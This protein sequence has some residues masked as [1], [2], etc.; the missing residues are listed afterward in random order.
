MQVGCGMD[1]IFKS[2]GTPKNAKQIE[3]KT[4]CEASMSFV[5]CDKNCMQPNFWFPFS[6]SSRFGSLR[7]HRFPFHATVRTTVCEKSRFFHQFG[8]QQLDNHVAGIVR[9]VPIVL[10]ADG[11]LWG[12][13]SAPASEAI[14]IA[15]R[16]RWC[17]VVRPMAAVVVAIVAAAS[18]FGFVFHFGNTQATADSPARSRTPGG[19]ARRP[20]T[21]FNHVAATGVW[22]VFPAAKRRGPLVDAGA[23]AFGPP[24]VVFREDKDGRETPLSQAGAQQQVR[25]VDAFWSGP[26][27]LLFELL[28]LSLFLFL[29]LLVFLLLFLFLPLLFQKF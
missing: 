14:V 1:E 20:A 6:V 12:F 2:V 5:F 18:V 11:I 4:F 27:Q 17:Q 24:P 26:L 10:V 3:S 13:G 9:L 23:G 22:L 28:F 21:V 25:P 8:L 19:R 29:S 15:V 16:D 7:F